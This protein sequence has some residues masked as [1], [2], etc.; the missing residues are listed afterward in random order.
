MKKHIY[1]IIYS[2][3]ENENSAN[4]I[5]SKKTFENLA[6]L[7]NNIKGIFLGNK[8]SKR[9]PF[10]KIRKENNKYFID[11]FD[12]VNPYIEKLFK[13]GIIRKNIFPYLFAKRCQSI[14]RKDHFSKIIYI[15]I[16]S[17]EEGICYIK[18]LKRLN[19]ARIFFEMHNINYEI[20]AFYR[21]SFEN[22]YCKLAY[23]YFFELARKNS[24]R[25]RIISLTRQLADIITSRLNIEKINIVPSGHDF[26]ISQPKAVNFN[27][28]KIEVIYVGF[29]FRYRDVEILIQALNYLSDKFYLRMVGG[30]TSERENLRKKYHS[31]I[32]QKKLLLGEPVAHFKI[33]EK[34]FNA[35]IAVI[36]LPSTGFGYFTSP[37]KLFEY[38]SVGLPI[39]ASDTPCLREVL[40]KDSALFFKPG[41]NQDLANKIE[42]M[43]RNEE[44]AKRISERAFRDSKKYTYFERAK[45]IYQLISRE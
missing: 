5:Q 23:K 15:R 42:Y 19:I 12:F 33:R 39:I 40:T 20:S 24:D 44:E 25:V 13:L 10:W 22:T 29:S 7:D 3:I 37:L 14:I 38:M 27:K 18:N 9:N 34:L 30:G 8:G 2:F 1:C 36:S 6:S 32:N 41:D 28:E 16:A 26:H 11:R 43:A 4:E 21:W 17:P 35:D 45:K 31:L